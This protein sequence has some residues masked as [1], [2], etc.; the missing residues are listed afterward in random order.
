VIKQLI[1]DNPAMGEELEN[2]NKR[3]KIKEN[4]RGE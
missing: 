1:L 3:K 4:K 2:K